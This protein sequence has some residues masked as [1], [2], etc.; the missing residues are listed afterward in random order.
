MKIL[1]T[2][3]QRNN[4][5]LIC[6]RCSIDLTLSAKLKDTALESAKHFIVPATQKQ[7][8]D[9]ASSPEPATKGEKQ[10][11]VIS[12]VLLN[13]AGQ[14]S[15]F[16]G[17]KEGE[18]K[19]IVR[20]PNQGV[21]RN[22]EGKMTA[23]LQQNGGNFPIRRSM[24]PQVKQE[25][26]SPLPHFKK[27]YN[28]VPMKKQC[29]GINQPEASENS[30]DAIMAAANLTG[31]TLK[32]VQITST[33]IANRSPM[34]ESNNDNII[35][36]KVPSP[37]QASMN[38]IKKSPT[39]ITKVSPTESPS[40][41]IKESSKNINEVTPVPRK[42]TPQ[43]KTP[44]RKR[45]SSLLPKPLMDSD[46][47]ITEYSPDNGEVLGKVFEV[48]IGDK[49]KIVNVQNSNG[50]RMTAEMAEKF[51]LQKFGNDVELKEV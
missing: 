22:S 5:P 37:Q 23:V 17:S 16:I 30:V 20:V 28:E 24:Q 1:F 45:K 36:S 14:L 2:Q 13:R 25:K 8:I 6:H 15:K 4:L 21:K 38:L 32:R 34:K 26:E 10:V 29:Q 3:L 19:F 31:V 27:T 43:R 50:K 18:Q 41:V 39:I 35:A 11:K 47:L 33:P 40:N 44:Q 46:G 12:S 48:K 7:V 9:L 49:T 51:L 42:S